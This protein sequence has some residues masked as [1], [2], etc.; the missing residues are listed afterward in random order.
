MKALANYIVR[1]PTQ[2]VLV[3]VIAAAFP[4]LYWISAAAVGLITLA[5]SLSAGAKVLFWALIPAGGWF[6]FQ[7][8]AG[9]ALVILVSWVM[10]IVL[11]STS[12][13]EAAIGSG[14]LLGVCAGGLS[15]YLMPDLLV[16]LV[17][18]SKK[19]YTEVDP[20][21]ITAMGDSVDVVLIA[22]MKGSFAATYFSLA[23]LGVVLA[24]SWQASLYNPEGFKK[25]FVAFRFSGKFSALALVGLF[26]SPALGE[27]AL[28]L[29]LVLSICYVFAG[30][31]LVHGIVAKKKLGW[32]WLFAFYVAAL[33]L[34]PSF[35][36]LLVFVAMLDSW[37]D[38][39][40]RA[41][42]PS[43]T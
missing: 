20:A 2:A 31:A 9:P 17:E 27:N 41:I 22:L 15:A 13:W 18:F 40:G 5:V 38:F 29:V 42:D 32:R 35:F 4:L 25:E 6:L 21:I 11:R 8:D 10:A 26:L 39:R 30:L 37:L 1:G 34:G 23:L 3:A 33:L 16:E 28:M 7:G 12:S 14:G 36:V 24:R 19:L 43:Q